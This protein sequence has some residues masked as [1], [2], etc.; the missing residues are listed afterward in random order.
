MKTDNSEDEETLEKQH[1]ENTDIMKSCVVRQ[2]AAIIEKTRITDDAK[3]S[4]AEK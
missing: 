3:R 1:R 4:T 2:W